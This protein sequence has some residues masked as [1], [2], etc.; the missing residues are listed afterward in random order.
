M[1]DAAVLS[2]PQIARKRRNDTHVRRLTTATTTVAIALAGVFTGL[3]T[4]ASTGSI[5][6]TKTE[7]MGPSPDAVLA[8]AIADYEAAA[9]RQSARPTPARSHAGLAPPAPPAPARTRPVA[10]SGGS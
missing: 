7:P 5:A 1:T 3:A 9:A 4:T 6:L 2:T 10:V 8:A